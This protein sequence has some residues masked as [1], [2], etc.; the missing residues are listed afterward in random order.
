MFPYV[1]VFQNEMT[2][3]IKRALNNYKTEEKT[4][5]NYILFSLPNKFKK[6]ID[7]SIRLVY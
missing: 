2:K 5:L 3:L 1:S 6:T 7:L 4:K